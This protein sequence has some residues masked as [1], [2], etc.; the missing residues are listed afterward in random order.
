[1][2]NLEQTNK[3]QIAKTAIAKFLIDLKRLRYQLSKEC[4]ADFTKI[5][6]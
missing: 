1:M 6:K 2:T 4:F 5:S 3:K